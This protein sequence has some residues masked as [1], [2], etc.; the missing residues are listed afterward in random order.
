V[1]DEAR[2]DAFADRAAE[3]ALGLVYGEERAGMIDHLEGCARCRAL[4]ESLAEAGDVLLVAVPGAEPAA[5]F[6][7]RVLQRLGSSGRRPGRKRG[8]W[9]G[10]RRAAPWMLAA[11]C[12]VVLLGVGGIVLARHGGTTDRVLAEAD[13]VTADG[14][15]VGDVY[16]HSGNGDGGAWILVEVPG[17]SPP[18]GEPARDYV[19]RVRDDAGHET[20]YPGLTLEAGHGAWGLAIPA[21]AAGVREVAVLDTAGRVWCSA[22][23]TA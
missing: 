13:M 23:L 6:E 10:F 12:L 7:G 1:K 5:G 16:V 17:W 8:G 4:V 20:T 2:C 11:A 3:F 22:T 14:T 9:P 19:L 18:P 21:G 15:R